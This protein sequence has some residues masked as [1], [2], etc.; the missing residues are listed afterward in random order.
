MRPSRL[1]RAD[2]RRPAFMVPSP[3]PGRPAWVATVTPT[4]GL[5]RVRRRE[6]EL[7]TAPKRRRRTPCS[8]GWP[9]CSPYMRLA[10]TSAST[11]A[12][13]VV[14]HRDMV[15]FVIPPAV[16]LHNDEGFGRNEQIGQGVILRLLIPSG[17]PVPKNTSTIAKFRGDGRR[18][19][20]AAHSSGPGT[21]VQPKE[22]SKGRGRDSAATGGQGDAGRVDQRAQSGQAREEGRG[23]RAKMAEAQR[24]LWAKLGKGYAAGG[25]ATL[26]EG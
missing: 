6:R 3:A 25:T 18:L 8:I 9:R 15:R 13:T 19:R 12:S 5:T 22:S 4:F 23:D 10:S 24:A 20:R 16:N 11:V 21:I 17:T 14:S 2:C 7:S 1:N 26:P